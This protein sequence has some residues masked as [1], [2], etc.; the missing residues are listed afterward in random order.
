MR[1]SLVRVQARTPSL[2][3]GN[4]LALTHHGLKANSAC[5]LSIRGRN[6]HNALPSLKRHQHNSSHPPKQTLFK[7]QNP[8]LAKQK[9]YRPQWPG[10]SDSTS[11]PPSS[12]SE[13]TAP[14]TPS[15]NKKSRYPTDPES[16]ASKL[17]QYL[18]KELRSSGNQ[19][20]QASGSSPQDAAD[21]KRKVM[22]ILNNAQSY[23]N[24]DILEYMSL[25]QSRYKAVVYL[26]D[27]LLNPLAV[28]ADNDSK[29]SLLPS[30]IRWPISFTEY[31][32]GPIHLDSSSYTWTTGTSWWEEPFNDATADPQKEKVMKIILPLLAKLTIA[33]FQLREIDE[34]GEEGV[35]HQLSDAEARTLMRTVH[36]ITARLHH[37]DLVPP[38]IYNYS[39]PTGTT[40][41]Q[42]P[43]ILHLL[44]SRILSS[45]SDSV[46]R[47][48]QDEAIEKALQQGM[49]YKQISRDVP[50]GRFRLKVRELG[51]EVWLEF[52]LWF[53]VEGGYASAGA[54]ILSAL[55]C[56]KDS[57]WYAVHWCSN[58]GLET[59]VPQ[60]DWEKARTRLGGTAGKL[61]GYSPEEPLAHIP[62]Q[63]VSAEVVLALIECLFNN[64]NTGIRGS[65]MSASKFQ[66][67]LLE[68]LSFLEPHALGPE[69]F[70]YLTVRFLQTGTSFINAQP[71]GLRS[72][73]HAISQ[74]RS[75]ETI[76]PPTGYTR[77]LNL[78]RIA[79]QTEL[80]AG[81]L[82]QALQ[83]FTNQNN[84]T[85]AVNCFTDIQRHVDSSRLESIGT[86]LMSPSQQNSGNSLLAVSDK[87]RP[88]FL[89]SHGQLPTY[90]MAGFLNMVT[91]AQLFGLGQ[92]LLNSIDVDGPLIPMSVYGDLCMRV[93]LNKYAD[94]TGNSDLIR[95]VVSAPRQC[96]K[97]LS[98]SALR[99]ITNALISVSEW[100]NASAALTELKLM[101]GGGYSP[102]IVARLGA[103]I[104]EIES[105][106][107]R[108]KLDEDL[109]EAI[110][111]LSDILAGVFDGPRFDFILST[112]RTLSQQ[113]GFLLR[114]FENVPP[115]K[116]R[117]IMHIPDSELGNR[118][119]QPASQLTD[120]A[121]R[122]KSK[123]PIS[124]DATLAPESFNEV[125]AAI[126]QCRGAVEGVRMWN[127]FCK[128]PRTSASSENTPLLDEYIAWESGAIDGADPLEH[129]LQMMISPI[130]ILSAGYEES[131]MI[132]V[133]EGD[134]DESRTAE[135]SINPIVVPN[136]RTL[137]IIVRGA[138]A[139]KRLLQGLWH[140]KEA[141]L[142]M[143]LKWATNY[144]KVFNYSNKETEADARL[145]EPVRGQNPSKAQ[146]KWLW[147][148]S[149]DTSG[150]REKVKLDIK[151]MF[152]A[153]APLTRLPETDRP[154]M[155]GSLRV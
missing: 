88:D 122:F 42:R 39:L 48:Q 4:I 131:S 94:A 60:V 96:G 26:A 82:H 149:A 38:E 134:P 19:S 145:P 128:D 119:H 27:L 85:E 70:N 55:R 142:N 40:N 83:G 135:G 58:H 118:G 7:Q 137:H 80:Q 43:P 102:N 95:Q 63:T 103:K 68:V 87:S 107:R 139:E 84:A 17:D 86:F 65:G 36:I 37:L 106:L 22:N 23:S 3:H 73:Y 29:G 144:Y 126:V 12:V 47:E 50:G 112:R 28:S 147:D 143:V 30:N 9:V 72:W 109:S 113:I 31:T 114:L 25:D 132:P 155:G 13:K 2:T 53:C 110:T 89:Q 59:P 125:L 81:V 52:L 15:E 35:L 45:L 5:A 79:A 71:D 34:E 127:M 120:L 51:P 57:P 105:Q 41:V 20:N 92:W 74:A 121:S 136:L 111:L 100:S 93:S 1:N 123:F 54:K 6:G 152:T 24:L 18:P 98:V 8:E 133:V 153:A 56:Q 116:E 124:N 61:E 130:P 75:L 115:V 117:D 14:V 140:E 11:H 16:W 90:K 64:I 150:I 49:S 91:N 97:G 141:D 101:P 76:K 77:S 46:W 67:Y 154:K 99:A 129:R 148:R 21:I 33:A 10:R 146:L 78:E 138:L 151:A 62:R 66:S 108:L 32:Y 104:I 44:S 69:Y